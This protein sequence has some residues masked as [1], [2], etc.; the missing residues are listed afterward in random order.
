MTSFRISDNT[1]II[2]NEVNNI[3]GGGNYTFSD[4]INIGINTGQGSNY[5]VN[6]GNAAGQTSQRGS[7][8]SIGRNC[9]NDRQGVYQDGVVNAGGGFCVAIG[10]NCGKYTQE[11]G[12]VGIGA[13][14]GKTN[15]GQRAIGI[16]DQ[17]GLYQQGRKAIAIGNAAGRGL[18][19]GYAEDIKNK[20]GNNSIAIG[21][22]S[23]MIALGQYSIC[24]GDKSVAQGVNAISIGREATTST[25]DNCISL[26]YQAECSADGQLGLPAAFDDA[27][28]AGA[29]ATKYLT[30]NIGGTIY[31]V[32]LLANA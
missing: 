2:G 11:V 30:L 31:K 28:T 9:G 4:P 5:C 21:Y 8:I 24:I 14:A 16:G 26:G 22:R 18:P 19:D 13:D 7:C 25:F 29:S 20:Q 10:Y 15:Q 32:E 23:G 27:T 12:A 6:I 3:G 17:A 1:V